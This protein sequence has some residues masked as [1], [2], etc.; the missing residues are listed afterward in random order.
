MSPSASRRASCPPFDL[1][2]LRWKAATV[3]YRLI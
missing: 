1:R 2:T 3:D